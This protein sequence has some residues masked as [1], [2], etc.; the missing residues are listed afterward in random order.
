MRALFYG[1]TARMPHLTPNDIAM[2]LADALPSHAS[3]RDEIIAVGIV[4]TALISG[5][6]PGERTELTEA[7]CAILRS[8]VAMDL[9]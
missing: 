6:A 5:A 1:R 8:S 7:F 4:A 3:R 9:N 2:S